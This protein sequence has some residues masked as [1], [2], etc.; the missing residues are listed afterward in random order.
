MRVRLIASVATIAFSAL[1][2]VGPVR[3]ADSVT[4]ATYGGA[5][6]KALS[7]AE[8]QPI[9]KQMGIEVKEVTVSSLNE[10]KVQ[11]DAGAVAIDVADLGAQDCQLGA[12]QNL[13]E[14]LDY[15]VIDASGVD[16]KLVKP[17]WVA[18]PSYYSTVLAWN[19]EKYG[20]N[21]PKS[22]ADFWNVEKFPG[23]R[24]LQNSPYAN[25]EIAL[26]ADGVKPADLYPLDV[27]RAFKKLR[28]IKPHITVWWTNGGQS[29]QLL[30][31]GE[32]D[33][34]SIWN[35]RA[36]TVIK[37]GAKAALTFN[38]GLLGVDCLVVPKGSKNK[39][40]AMK[41]INLILSADL[42]A[43]LPALIEYGP[44]NSK[45][46]DTGKITPELAAATNSSPENYKLQ[47]TLDDEWW[48]KNLPKIQ[49]MWDAFIQE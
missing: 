16:Q 30:N 45:A 6:A 12:D 23:N 11:V 25:L 40:L 24:A 14:P 3:A 7:E 41:V 42:Q 15:K 49:P 35:G 20:D 17:S 22:W 5:W 21:P 31:D 9:S 47:V 13:W 28:E 33:M 38:E 29:A 39:D 18:G 37:A 2:A 10:V 34:E 4:V 26:M 27:E 46:F 43:N 48:G 44:V 36:S 8:L 1:V 32:V 19:T